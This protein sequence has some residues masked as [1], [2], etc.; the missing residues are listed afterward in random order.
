MSISLEEM[1][2]IAK[3]FAIEPWSNGNLDVFDEVCSPDYRL[4]IG[5]GASV[6]DLKNAVENFR[7]AVPDLKIEI[8]KMIAE[9]DLVA[10]QWTMRGTHL[11]P[12]YDQPP[13]GKAITSS[14]ITIVRFADGKIVEDEFE[15]TSADFS[16]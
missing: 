7:R 1:K 2:T 4:N 3:R 9:G 6:Q 15:G 16:A 12:L 10:Y 13:T 11:G 8:H 5:D 14:G